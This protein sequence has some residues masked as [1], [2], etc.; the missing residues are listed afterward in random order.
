MHSSVAG[1]QVC[2]FVPTSTLGPTSTLVSPKPFRE[3]GGGWRELGSGGGG[4]KQDTLV[5]VWK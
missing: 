1:R 3:D 2:D 5:A 4:H